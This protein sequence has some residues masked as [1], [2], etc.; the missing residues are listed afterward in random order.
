MERKAIAVAVCGVESVGKR[1]FSSCRSLAMCDKGEP[2][3]VASDSGTIDGDKC[4]VRRKTMS[5]QC[6][7]GHVDENIVVGRFCHSPQPEEEP[8]GPEPDVTALD[9]L[10]KVCVT[11]FF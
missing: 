7:G 3:D 2:G 5:T 4:G 1:V 9:V 6:G 8:V 11:Y 10:N